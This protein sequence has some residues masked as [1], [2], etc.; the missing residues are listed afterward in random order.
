M[1]DLI[2][3]LAEL[4]RGSTVDRAIGMAFGPIDQPQTAA[5]DACRGRG[6]RDSAHAPNAA[7]RGSDARA[8]ARA[9]FRDARRSR[10]RVRSCDQFL[11]SGIAGFTELD[12]TPLAPPAS[13][14]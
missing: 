2:A 9:P 10:P 8:V 13:A 4:G 5:S 6:T 14:R 11:Q 1:N 12:Q 7:T 3:R